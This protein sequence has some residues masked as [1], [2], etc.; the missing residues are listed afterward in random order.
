[1]LVQ[2]GPVDRGLAIL[3]E[4]LVALGEVL[5]PQEASV[6]RQGRRVNGLEQVVLL[7]VDDGG[8]L[9]GVRA[10]QQEHDAVAVVAEITHRCCFVH[11]PTPNP[12]LSLTRRLQEIPLEV[13]SSD[14][15]YLNHK[16]SE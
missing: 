1:M 6:G 8:F 16:M 10:P 7:G 9:V 11:H 13:L 5:A 4:Q 2:L 12:T 14:P 15:N 3:L